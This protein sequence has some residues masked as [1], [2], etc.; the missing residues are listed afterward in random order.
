MTSE[1]GSAPFPAADPPAER[2]ALL[3]TA[4]RRGDTLALSELLELLEPYV[5]RVCGPIALDGGADAAQETLIAVMRGIGSL[6]NP[7]AVFGWV[8]TIAVRESVRH[9][10]RDRSVA[11]ITDAQLA[12]LPATGSPELI[13]DVRRVL[14]GLTPEQRAV[15][16]LRDLHG[17]DE[18]A[19]AA[20]LQ[21]PAGTVKSRLHRARGSFRKAWTQ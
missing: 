10:R 13:V 8:R 4:A 2:A 16:V 20:L 12:E 11:V 7:A 6:Q 5:R 14:A 9:A 1:Q 18:Q 21:I 19:A 3:V 17:F 15:L